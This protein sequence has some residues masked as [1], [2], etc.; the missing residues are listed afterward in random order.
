MVNLNYDDEREGN[1]C[2]GTKMYPLNLCDGECHNN[3]D[4]ANGNLKALLL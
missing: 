4:C 1:E 2:E 3:S